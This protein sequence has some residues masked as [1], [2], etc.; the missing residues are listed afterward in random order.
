MC[1]VPWKLVAI[2]DLFVVESVSNLLLEDKQF[3]LHLRVDVPFAVRDDF[4]QGGVADLIPFVCVVHFDVGLALGK[5]VSQLHGVIT[6]LNDVI[7]EELLAALLAG[8]PGEPLL[9][10]LCFYLG[11]GERHL[12]LGLSWRQ[13]KHQLTFVAQ[14]SRERVIV[15]LRFGLLGLRPGW[16]R[17]ML[18]S[19]LLLFSDELISLQLAS[20]S[21][22]RTLACSV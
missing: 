16:F 6:I 14:A 11:G 10:I 3:V 2:K 4:A 12:C 7:A 20:P 22:S 8:C 1:L 13:L 9:A 17:R 19:K 15:I 18:C 21:I 5:S